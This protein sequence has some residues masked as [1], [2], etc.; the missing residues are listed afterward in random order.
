MNLRELFYSQVNLFH[1]QRT[2][3]AIVEHVA[4]QLAVDRR[5]LGFVATAKGLCAG[6]SFALDAF[7]LSEMVSG[8]VQY[9]NQRTGELIDG[10]QSSNGQ[11][12]VDEEIEIVESE[13]RVTFILVVEKDTVFQVRHPLENTRLVSPEVIAAFTQRPFLNA[14]LG[15]VFNH[16]SRST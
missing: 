3:D 16:R 9:R 14:L 8:N 11:L 6:R 7:T 12:I 1:H 5:Q 15:C 4:Q 2:S 10:S 13:H